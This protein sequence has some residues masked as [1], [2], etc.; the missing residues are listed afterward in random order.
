MGKTLHDWVCDLESNW[1]DRHRTTQTQV[2]FKPGPSHRTT[3]WVAGKRATGGAWKGRPALGSHPTSS[4]AL[5]PTASWRAA[6]LQGVMWEA[7]K[8]TLRGFVTP[9]WDLLSMSWHHIVMPSRR[10]GTHAGSQRP[11]NLEAS[12]KP[13]LCPQKQRSSWE[14]FHPAQ[15]S[16]TQRGQPG[17]PKVTGRIPS[18]N[19]KSVF[20][21][22]R[23][24]K[25]RSSLV[26]G[27][28]S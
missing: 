22:R 4:P 2:S 6:T 1:G 8:S 20:L 11:L 26:A 24:W 19:C 21:T 27:G 14:N 28:Y 3:C 17:S 9:F 23:V 18:T 13:S 15:R 7:M 12:P 25:Q 10:P 16:S 5:V